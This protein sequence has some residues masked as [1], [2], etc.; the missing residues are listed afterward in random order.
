MD[1]KAEERSQSVLTNV[2]VCVWWGVGGVGWNYQARNPLSYIFIWEFYTY[3]FLFTFWFN[4]LNSVFY[5]FFKTF[6]GKS[7]DSHPFSFQNGRRQMPLTHSRL[8]ND[9]ISQFVLSSNF[10]FACCFALFCVVFCLFVLFFACLC[11]FCFCFVLFLKKHLTWPDYRLFY[12]NI[13]FLPSMSYTSWFWINEV[14]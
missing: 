14:I 4:V 12:E 5:I 1:R 3:S 2:C 10:F 9:C 11:C 8:L 13:W 6:D 7:Y